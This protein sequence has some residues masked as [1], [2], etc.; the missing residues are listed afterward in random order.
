MSTTT[1]KSKLPQCEIGIFGGSGF[2]ELL[3]S[4]HEIEINTPYGQPSDKISIGEI[5][6]RKIAFLPRHSK[7]HQFSPHTIPY[8]ANLWAY[9]MLGITRVLAPAA[10]GSL[11]AHIQP[12]DF[13]ICDQ[14]IDRTKHR[15][16]TYYPGPKT[17][18]ISCAEPYCPQ[19]RKVA[20]KSCQ[21]LTIPVHEK[22]EVV[23]IEGP[24]FS[25][26]AESRWYQKSNFEVINMTQ[27]PEVV[28]ARELE[29]CYV[30]IS[31]ITDWDAGLVGNKNIKPVSAADVIKIFNKNIARVKELIFEMVKTMPKERTCE[32]GKALEGAEL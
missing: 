6:G 2:Y 18:H 22:G 4:A 7:K 15:D 12:G 11:Q 25:T 21:K 32:C 1:I 19:L 29:M 27:Y 9:K 5:A 3:S 28:L 31:L 17:V 26:K 20:I 10:A 13:V 16:E 14:F 23:I 30:N 24:R 8:R